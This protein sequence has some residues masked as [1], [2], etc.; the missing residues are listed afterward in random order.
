MNSWLSFFNCTKCCGKY[1][2][3]L[4][5]VYLGLIDVVASNSVESAYR[6]SNI[7]CRNWLHWTNPLK[8]W[9]IGSI[10]EKK[11]NTRVAEGEHSQYTNMIYN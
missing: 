1:D 2:A 8:I 9:F 5:Y 11:N 7:S 4:C 3:D 10:M 6:V